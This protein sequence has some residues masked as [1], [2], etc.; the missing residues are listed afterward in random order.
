M[1]QVDLHFKPSVPVFDA[2]VALGRRHDRRVAVDTVEGTQAAMRRAGVARALVHSAHAVAFDAQDGNEYLLEMIRGE[3]SLVPQLALDPNGHDLGS[4]A[5]ETSELGV[6][7]VRMLPASGHYPFKDWVVG[8]WLEW[9]ASERLPL[10]VPAPEIDPAELH[11]TLKGHPQLAV[12]MCEVHYSHASWVFPLLRSLPNL[13]IEIS[14][15]VIPDGIARL[16]ESVGHERVLFG[17]W[18]PDSPIAPQL[19]NLHRC[20]LGDQA[21]E[22][23]CAGNL[24]RLLSEA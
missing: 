10:W 14:R 1:G 16:L 19:Y 2:N 21:L 17:S 8:P 24:Q 4:F 7:S 11:D 18:F 13:H 3:S 22:A 15:F 12:V 20:G 6:R 5:A 9:L 23:V